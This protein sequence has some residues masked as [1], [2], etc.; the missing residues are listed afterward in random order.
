MS[1]ISRVLKVIVV[2]ALAF[3]AMGALAGT[4]S[5]K[6]FVTE[7]GN[8]ECLMRSSFVRCDIS[9]HFWESPP[10]PKSC[11]F[12]YGSTLG[13]NKRGKAKWLCVSDAIGAK[14]VA[15]AGEKIE[16]GPYRC[17]VRKKGVVC[18]YGNSGGFKLTKTRWEIF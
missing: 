6:K 2:S 8:V 13:L 18:K 4:A 7:D 1:I 11:E 15:M 16:V 5:A 10:K 3:A 12:D 9:K 14:K 17:S